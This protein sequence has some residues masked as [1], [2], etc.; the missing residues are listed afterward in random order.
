M[1]VQ[2]IGGAG[3]CGGA[4]GADGAAAFRNTVAGMRNVA[5]QDVGGSSGAGQGSSGMGA[6]G[7]A[8]TGMMPGMAGIGSA[9]NATALDGMVQISGPRALEAAQAIEELYQSNAI[10]RQ[11]IDQAR[12]EGETVS[13]QTGY[14]G[15]NSFSTLE[16]PGNREQIYLNL[17]QANSTE[18]IAGLVVHELGH[19][20]GN[21]PDGALGSIGPNQ[22][23][24]AEV[25]GRTAVAYGSANGLG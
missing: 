10:F 13:I 14:G 16:A 8:R 17:D 7:S 2:G 4:R 1:A 6:G 11:M 23:F 19:A 9:Q 5:Q 18:G 20:F 25:F 22:R 12:A 24:R 3:G 21:L 15:G